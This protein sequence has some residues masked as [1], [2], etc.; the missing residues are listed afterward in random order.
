MWPSGAIAQLWTMGNKPCSLWGSRQSCQM[1]D[2]SDVRCLTGGECDILMDVR[3]ALILHPIS[4]TD[5][6]PQPVQTGDMVGKRHT[7]LLVLKQLSQRSKRAGC[8]R[9][10]KQETDY[11]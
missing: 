4:F 5:P 7:S 9:R 3:W 6:A 10:G 8:M 1:S 2:M 11:F